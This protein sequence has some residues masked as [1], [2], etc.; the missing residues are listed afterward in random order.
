MNITL[1]NFACGSDL[2]SSS[3]ARLSFKKI[4]AGAAIFLQSNFMLEFQ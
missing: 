1:R 3:S 2:A 4:E